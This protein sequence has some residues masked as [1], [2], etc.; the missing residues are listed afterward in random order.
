[1]ELRPLG[2]GEIFDR[3]ITLYIRNFIPFVGIVSVFVIPLSLM[4][5]FID[6]ASIPQWDSMLHTLE[7]PG[8]AAPPPVLPA[9]L[10]SPEQAALFIARILVAWLLWPFALNACTVGVA[11]LY[12]GSAVEFGACYRASLARW[13]PVI[14]L[15]CLEAVVFVVWYIAFVVPLVLDVVAVVALSQAGPLGAAVAILAAIVGLVFAV[16][17]LALLAPLFV[18][19]SF[20]M[21][22]IVIEERPAVSALTLGFARVF[23]RREFWRALLFA[24]AAGAIVLGAQTL[25]SVLLLVA[26]TLHLIALEVFLSS[27]F[28]IAITPFS[29]VLLAIYYFDVRIRREGFEIE[30]ELDRL[31]DS[32]RVA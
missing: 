31:A 18:A 27:L 4:Q 26:M 24:L 22:A 21:N 8:Q 29:V 2:F 3:A 23:N 10:S 14:G 20:S 13:A 11:R 7:H 9:F 5:Y 17:W 32:P 16:V 28:Q 19:L 25:I 30:A 12:R 15:L 6:R 1:M